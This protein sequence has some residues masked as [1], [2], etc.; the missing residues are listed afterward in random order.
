MVPTGGFVAA[1]IGQ[2]MGLYDFSADS[3]LLVSNLQSAIG[4]ALGTGEGPAAGMASIGA[5]IPAGIGQGLAQYSFATDA[6]LLATNLQGALSSAF[7]GTASMNAIA[8]GNLLSGIGS[9][10]VQLCPATSTMASAITSS[11]SGYSNSLWASGYNL[12]FGMAQGIL[13]GQS[14]VI[15][16]AVRVAQAAIRAANNTLE[17]HSPSRVLMETGQKRRAGPCHRHDERDQCRRTSLSKR[18]KRAD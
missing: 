12:S 15:N 4:A 5:S 7:A 1:G 17:V 13:S 6:V 3:A 18:R 16:A 11:M 9:D 10:V 2:G 14:T 8:W